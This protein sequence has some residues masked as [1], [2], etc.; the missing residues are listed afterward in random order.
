[1]PRRSDAAK[2]WVW[3]EIPYSEIKNEFLTHYS[4]SKHSTLYKDLP[5]FSQWIDSMNEENKFVYWNLAVVDGDNNENPWCISEGVSAGQIER[6]RKK[7]KDYIDIGSLRSGL[8]ALC[9]AK[10]DTM[11]LEQKELYK[12]VCKER[13]DIISERNNLNLGDYPLLLVYR[14]KK[15]GGTPRA[16]SKQREKLNT[17]CDIIGISIIIPGDSIGESH[18]KSL[19]IKIRE[20]HN[21]A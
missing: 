20:E 18:A 16:N 6:T 3:D 5:F 14:I 10:V 2:A 19:R 15:N 12:K 1:M 4:I 9:D 11:S 17:V 21:D 13:K 7:G 8:D